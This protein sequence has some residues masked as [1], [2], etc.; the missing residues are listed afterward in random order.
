MLFEPEVW[1]SNDLWC[2]GLHVLTT[3]LMMTTY[4]WMLCE[5]TFLRM[6]LIKTFVEEENCLW[7]FCF[8][9]WVL[10]LFVIIPY[11]GYRVNYENKLCWMDPGYSVIFLSVP[12]IIVIA[13][14]IFFLCS[15]IK[16]LK[17]KLQFE[18]VFTSHGPGGSRLSTGSTAGITL[19]SAR[20]VVILI[21]IF[22]LQF[23]L[24][25]I[26]PSK[27]SS[28]EYCYE[29]ISSLSTS[30]Q[31]LAVSILLCF[32][33]SEV[34]TKIKQAFQKFKI[35]ATQELTGLYSSP[36][37]QKVLSSTYNTL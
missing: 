31:G 3:Y 24:L 1:S 10:P 30:T 22:G 34:L 7:R 23:L 5:G 2:R 16:V 17:S 12:V 36:R 32:T 33:N 4:F 6:I 35:N 14:N 18:A 8:L 28:F 25:P 9:G 26:R 19:K 27:G 13:I 11:V 20:A 29:I 37:N 15:V 21:P